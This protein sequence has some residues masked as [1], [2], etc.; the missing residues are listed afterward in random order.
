MTLLGLVVVKFCSFPPRRGLMLHDVFAHFRTRARR[1]RVFVALHGSGLAE[2]RAEVAA[3]EVLQ[4]DGRPVP[5]LPFPGGGRLRIVDTYKHLGRFVA[6][7]GR[8]ARKVA[9]RCSSAAAATSAPQKRVFSNHG[10]S[11]KSR[12]HVAL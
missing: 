4:D 1:K 8:M 7:S 10:L 2:A 3:L 9:F 6:G 5:L 11:I 12:S